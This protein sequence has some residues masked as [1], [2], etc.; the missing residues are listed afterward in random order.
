MYVPTGFV[1]LPGH[2]TWDQLRQMR[3][4]GRWQ[5]EEHAGDGHV[6]ITVDATGRR[7]PSTPNEQWTD[8]KQETFAHYKQRVSSDIELGA[9]LLARNLPGWTPDRT[10]RCPFG[11]YGQ[12]RLERPPHRA[13]A[14]QLPEDAV[15]RHLRPAPRRLRDARA[16]ASRTGSLCF[17]LGCRHARDAPARRRRRAETGSRGSTQRASQRDA[18][19]AISVSGKLRS[20]HR[21]HCDV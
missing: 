5:I 14:T 6:P 11:D 2:L 12:T 16:R 18:P 13:V 4:S 19:P 7:R 1:G 15:R 17:G 10:L 20:T 8:G 3:A 21:A 9:A